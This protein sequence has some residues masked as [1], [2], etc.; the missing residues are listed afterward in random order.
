[1][2]ACVLRSGGPY[3]PEHVWRLQAQ[4][5]TF[6]PNEPF[7]CLSDVPVKGVTTVPLLHDWPGWWAKLE[8]FRDDVFPDGARVLYADLDTTFVGPIERL[9]GRSE[10]FIALANFYIRAKRQTVGGELGSGLMQWTAGQFG[11]LYDDFAALA[12]VV[13]QEC[14]AFGD[15]LFLDQTV[16]ERKYWQDVL[17]GAVVSYKLHCQTRVPQGASVACFHGQPKPWQVPELRAA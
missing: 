11:F 2:I 7:V 5:A 17:P 16:G 14:G 8:L 12:P 9:L 13:M 10:T 4:A 6:A 3:G 15:Q 1:M